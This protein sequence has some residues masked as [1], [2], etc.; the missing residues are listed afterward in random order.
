[1]GECG[2]GNTNPD[3][4]FDGPDGIIYTVQF[5]TG[6]NNGCETPS[7]IILSRYLPEDAE[8]AAHAKEV[9]WNT[10]GER[11]DESGDF[12]IPII[13]KDVLREKLVAFGSGV[14][15]GGDD[16]D[17]YDTLDD[18]LQDALGECLIDAVSASI[19]KWENELKR[20]KRKK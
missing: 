14:V 7:G 11:P 17:G 3:Y 5:Y 6:C 19:Q 20:Q 12:C 9:P 1:M 13:D 16:P 8:W 2:C 18:F 15:I 4:R 10:F